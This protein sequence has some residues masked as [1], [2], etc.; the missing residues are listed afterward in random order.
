MPTL[1]FLARVQWP[2]RCYD[3]VTGRNTPPPP[4]RLFLIDFSSLLGHFRLKI[5]ITGI[6]NVYRSLLEL[7][8][9]YLPLAFLYVFTCHVALHIIHCII[10]L[11]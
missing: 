1:F 10:S 7:V 9:T 3:Y 8:Y 6:L 11:M 2:V 4:S 5:L